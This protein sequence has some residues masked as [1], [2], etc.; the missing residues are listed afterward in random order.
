[1]TELAM[2][3]K[4]PIFIVGLSRGGSS[5]MLNI[6]RSHPVVCSPR[7]ETSQVF[8]GKPDEAIVTRLSKI[9]RYMPTL[10]RQ[11]EHLFSPHRYEQRRPLSTR[12]AAAI[13]KILFDDKMLALD[14]TQNRY[15]AEGVENTMEEIRDSRLLSK[16]IDGAAFLTPLFASMYPDATFFGLVRN[17]LAVCEGHVRRGRTATA[18]GELYARVCGQ[19]LADA[20]RLPNF[21]LIRYEDLSGNTLDVA[22]RVFK[23]AKLDADCVTKYRLIVG[24]EGDEGRLG[25][26]AKQLRWYNPQE[27]ADAIASGI[28]EEQI[29]KLSPKHRN[30]FLSEAGSVMELLGYT[31]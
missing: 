6:L 22:S 9:L 17:G 24:N 13:D 27:F 19:L 12:S 4:K 15:R 5:I 25:G 18:Y 23:F 7:G 16:S 28:D 21:H 8:Y 10:I 31:T 14:D 1:M 30:D 2:L 11:R 3:N 20:D 29:R 26:T